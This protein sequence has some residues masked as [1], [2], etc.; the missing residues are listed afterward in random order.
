METFKEYGYY[1]PLRNRPYELLIGAE[2][3]GTFY[4]VNIYDNIV[5]PVYY[6]FNGTYYGGGL[7]LDKYD[8]TAYVYYRR[9][10]REYGNEVKRW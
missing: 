8:E 3:T 4:G 7:F 6:D 9:C 10:L 2:I 5:T 1:K